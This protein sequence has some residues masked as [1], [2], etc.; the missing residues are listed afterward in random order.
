LSRAVHHHA[1]ELQ[2]SVSEVQQL[3][4]Q[5]RAVCAE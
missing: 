1:Y 4:G 2:R 5:V 3:L